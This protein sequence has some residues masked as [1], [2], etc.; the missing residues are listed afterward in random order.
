MYE[1]ND[2][3]LDA[4]TGG[5]QGNGNAFGLVAAGIGV[6]VDIG[7]VTVLNNNTVNILS[8]GV[9]VQVPI[10]VAASILGISANAIRATA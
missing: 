1:L 6:G 2:A 7:D 4:V 10:G 3:E 5:A 9:N 8:N